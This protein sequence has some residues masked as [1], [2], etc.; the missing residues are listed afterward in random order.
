MIKIFSVVC[1]AALALFSCTE[2]NT[3][4]V[5]LEV[6]PLS[7]EF[8]L[9]GGTRTVEITAGKAWTATTADSW[10]DVTPE[11]GTNSG[12]IDITVG[13]STEDR[14]GKVT[15]TDGTTTKTVTVKVEYLSVGSSK[16]LFGPDG[17]TREVKVMADKSWN[18]TPSDSWISIDTPSGDT[19][20]AFN[21][22]V[23]AG[24]TA[25]GTITV[26]DGV[27]TKTIAVERNELPGD[28]LYMAAVTN[29][30]PQNGP[31]TIRLDLGSLVVGGRGLAG[32]GWFFNLRI[33]ISGHSLEHPFVD[34]PEG[35]Y[36][37]TGSHVLMLKNGYT[38]P[39]R[40]YPESTMPI[41][42][43]TVVVN[44]NTRDGYVVTVEL[45]LRNGENIAGYYIGNIFWT[46]TTVRSTIDDDY[47]FP[48]MHSGQITFA[49]Q[50][51]AQVD[52]NMWYVEMQTRGMYINRQGY[53]AGDGTVVQL[54]LTTN[55]DADATTGLPEGTYTVSDA[56]NSQFF[57][58]YS[59]LKGAS[60]GYGSW[61][62]MFAGGEGYSYDQVALEYGG[63]NVS[64]VVVAR[65]EDGGYTITLD[66]IDDLGHRITGSYTIYTPIVD[67][68]TL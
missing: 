20:G 57:T 46:N 58:P 47:E 67:G 1:A 44:G 12:T 66:A 56:E 21:V 55:L 6:S 22:T 7:V 32:N 30:T 15:V 54:M 33:P 68:T 24:A 29:T 19:D 2:K 45:T 50:Q 41:T 31:Q 3:T 36:T 8:G 37:V 48:E 14:T 10:I 51:D 17:G 61:I 9:R 62:L 27:N 40:F 63:D 13:V 18:A 43:G 16:L 38:D 26:T 28:L 11:G 23:E 34:I 42:T 5:V 35:T 65:S 4:D 52:I 59:V 49:G 39:N 60:R 53:L 25:S 64:K